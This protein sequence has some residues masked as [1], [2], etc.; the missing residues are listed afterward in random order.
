MLIVCP[1]CATSYTVELPSLGSAGRSVRCARCKNV[2]FAAAPTVVPALASEDFFDI[3]DT[4][5]TVPSLDAP[6]RIDVAKAATPPRA[7]RAPAEPAQTSPQT[8]HAAPAGEQADAVM[9]PAA[10]ETA[11]ETA[12]PELTGE[13]PPEPASVEG[14]DLEGLRQD[15][16]VEHAEQAAEADAVLAKVAAAEMPA[17]EAPSLVPSAE[18]N[19]TAEAPVSAGAPDANI[20]SLAARRARRARG[21]KRQWTAPSLPTL[22]LALVA[23]NTILA[24]WR[25][26]IVRLLPQTAPLYAAIGL[27][28]NLRGLAFENVKSSMED[29]DGLAVLVVQ[30]AIHNVTGRAAK[31]PQIRLAVRNRGADEIYA[32][33]ARPA[34]SILA[35]G[36]TLAFRARLASPPK[37][38]RDVQVRFFTR[39]DIVAGLH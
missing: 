38:T 39:H 3:V 22:V 32:W 29:Q 14:I 9:A 36:E 23:A 16:E 8:G 21:H 12:A 4:G 17:T 15:M 28:V 30:G 5:P 6:R 11:P 18:P 24:A 1:Q 20:G 35:A 19:A 10:D 26:D 7:A 34:R 31:V 2:W 27:P 13:A 37:D 33:T 25:T